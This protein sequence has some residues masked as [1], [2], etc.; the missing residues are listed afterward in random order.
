[1]WFV[2]GEISGARRTE[3]FVRGLFGANEGS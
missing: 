3:T 1:L 2:L